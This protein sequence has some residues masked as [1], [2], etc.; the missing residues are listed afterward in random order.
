M[1]VYEAWFEKDEERRMKTLKMITGKKNKEGR[2]K[3]S[4]TITRE[5]K[6]KSENVKM[7]VTVDTCVRFQFCISA[8]F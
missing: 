5:K 3:I 4:R 6:E 8:Q 7:C 1:K 2:I